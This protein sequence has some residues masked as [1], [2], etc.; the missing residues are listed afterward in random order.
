[1]TVTGHMPRPQTFTPG[2][3]LH[4]IIA[5]ICLWLRFRMMRLMIWVKVRVI[6]PHPQ[7]GGILSNVVIR[8]LVCLSVCPMLMVQ[9]RCIL[10]LGLLER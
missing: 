2:Q 7:G 6:M 10:W 8:P 3:L 5:D 9:M 4:H 1:M